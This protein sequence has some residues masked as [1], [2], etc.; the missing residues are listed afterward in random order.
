MITV[1]ISLS[2]SAQKMPSADAIIAR[3]VKVIGGEKRWAEIKTSEFHATATLGD[4][5]LDMLVIKA[6]AGR[7]YQSL[8]GERISSIAIYDSGKGIMI[9]NER[10]Q[11]MKDPVALD[12][13][14]LQA[15]ILPDMNYIKLKYK[16]EV[17]GLENIN[18]EPCYKVVLTSKNGSVN[19][20]YYEKKSGLLILVEKKGV[21]TLF[22]D[23]KFYKGCSIPFT[24]SADLGNGYIMK[25]KVTEWLVNEKSSVELYNAKKRQLEL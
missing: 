11:V 12:H 23:Y 7:Y 18:N 1:F 3:Y 17:L 15:C 4:K 2:A 25:E 21:K 6:G 22:T 9:E 16:R 20:N 19:T 13:Y 8:L 5:R 10:K 24:M 14:E